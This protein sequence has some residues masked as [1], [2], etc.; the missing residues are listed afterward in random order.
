MAV[1]S[2]I[3]SF[4]RI[5]SFLLNC[6][7]RIMLRTDSRYVNAAIVK[8]LQKQSITA[9]KIALI[10]WVS[11]LDSKGLTYVSNQ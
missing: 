2:Q 5:M 8:N 6:M 9:R 7:V 1:K 3:S 10:S 11:L 4:M